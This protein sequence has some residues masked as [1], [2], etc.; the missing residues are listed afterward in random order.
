MGLT[1]GQYET[2]GPLLR[3]IMESLRLE[4]PGGP[5]AGS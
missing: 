2:D 1:V 5:A 3:P 4:S